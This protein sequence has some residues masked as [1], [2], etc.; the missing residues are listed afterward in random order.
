[1]PQEKEPLNPI[2]E[3]KAKLNLSTGNDFLLSR[4]L[5]HRSYI[6]ENRNAI[7]DNERLEFLGD[8]IISF[9]V[10]EWIYNK[11][12]DKPEGSLTK[13]RSALVSTDQLAGFAR[14]LELGKILNLGH[15]EDQ[16]GG[17]ERNAILCDAFE[18]LIAAIYLD[19][20]L[21]SVVKVM[22][23]FI[24]P[25]IDKIFIDHQDE[26]PKSKLQEW[27]QSQG[28]PSPRYVEIG[29]TGPD[30]AK[31]FE[32]SVLIND[33]SVGIGIGS[34]KQIAEKLAAQKALAFLGQ[35]E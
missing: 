21:D 29:A 32:M 26:D 10:A 28:L 20:G 6:N 18:A 17:R 3:L 11:F 1:M 30:H 15:G 13:L 35:T 16:A 31:I 9:V 22:D 27:V 19:A 4:A 25:T 8:A 2:N 5:T 24:S 23:E 12:P 14:Q 33:Q 34:S 7:E